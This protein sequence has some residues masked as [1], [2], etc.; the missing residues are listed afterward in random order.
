[1]AVFKN[2]RRGREGMVVTCRD[3][4]P[5][6]ALNAQAE[7]AAEAFG[8]R[9]IWLLFPAVMLK[10]LSATET[11]RANSL[12]SRM[13][14]TAKNNVKFHGILRPLKAPSG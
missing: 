6:A 12:R 10:G 4:L 13:P 8:S 9:S 1:M 5:G 2:A 11:S 7:S 3:T 14:A